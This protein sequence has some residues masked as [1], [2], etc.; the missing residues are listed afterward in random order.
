MAIFISGVII[1]IEWRGAVM[2]RWGRVL[3]RIILR[4]KLVLGGRRYRKSSVLLMRISNS[5]WFSLREGMGRLILF[6][7]D[8]MISQRWWIVELFLWT[9]PG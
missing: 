2:G 9:R 1:I 4:R 8:A 3:N 5:C 7:S 6:M